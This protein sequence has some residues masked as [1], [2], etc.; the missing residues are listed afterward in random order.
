MRHT[1]PNPVEA[2]LR[3]RVAVVQ[4]AAGWGK[5]T[6]ARR[7]VEGR[8]HR[9]IDLAAAPNQAGSAALALAEALGLDLE[10]IAERVAEAQR[11]GSSRELVDRLAESVGAGEAPL[12][13]FDD[14]HRLGDDPL[15]LDLL[16]GIVERCEATAFI[17]IARHAVRLPFASW[18]AAGFA[19]LPVTEDDL[20]LGAD[21][22][23]VLAESR[24]VRSDPAAIDAIVAATG[25]WPVA[26]RFALLAL[27]RDPQIARMKSITRDIAF[28][29]FAE[30]ILEELSEGQ[31]SLLADLALAGGFDEE[32]IVDLGE[33][34]LVDWLKAAPLPMHRSPKTVRLHDMFADFIE[35]RIPN[36]ERSERAVRVAN[37]LVQRRRIGEAFD[38]LC[39][40]APSAVRDLLA[41]E[42]FHLIDIG[43]LQAVKDAIGRIPAEARRTDPAMLLLRAGVASYE[44]DLAGVE[45]YLRS[46]LSANPQGELRRLATLSLAEHYRAIESGDGIEVVQPLLDSGT[47]SQRCEARSIH[48]ILLAID[49]RTEAAKSESAQAMGLAEKADDE[50]LT[51]RALC[52]RAM[53]YAYSGDLLAATESATTAIR[54]GREAGDPVIVWSALTCLAHA[55]DVL[56]NDREATLRYF[57]EMTSVSKEMNNSRSARSGLAKQYAMLVERGADGELDGIERDIGA[58]HARFMRFRDALEF[59]FAKAVRLA[60]RGEFRQGY[61]L[62]DGIAGESRQ[63]SVQRLHHARTA[64]FAVL[65]D[66]PKDAAAHLKACGSSGSAESE[67]WRYFDRSADICAALAEAF[68]GRSASA[69]RRLP[70][71]LRKRE[72][73]LVRAVRGL[74]ALNEH[75][76]PETVLPVVQELMDAEQEGLANLISAAAS[77]GTAPNATLALTP[78]EIAIFRSLA[79]GLAPKVIAAESGRSVDTVRNHIKSA[80]RKMGVSGQR[81]ALALA[82]RLGVV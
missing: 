48:A 27:E 11:S 31:R 52:Y 69:R 28:D 12:F 16:K 66:R 73:A 62:L 13:V 36:G 7:A 32:L 15:S 20:G 4:A 82:R 72:I 1:A 68:L 81:E 40:H 71:G 19:S 42:G 47:A 6:A 43:R 26:V 79:E 57:R 21:E 55:H 3:Y 17:L 59:R 2:A 75:L 64:L 80:I 34:G 44:G 77:K 76:T 30:Q 50:A 9:W 10:P 51:R 56:S 18:C 33:P 45:R 65:A 24:S 8:E 70:V 53:V 58:D 46:A 78:T 61:D 5:T 63:R 60:W 22:I 37:V 54:L 38:L 14:L 35:A 23:R 49:G 74:A 25:G 39:R 29:Y 41:E 67:W